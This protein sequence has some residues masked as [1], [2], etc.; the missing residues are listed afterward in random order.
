MLYCDVV[1]Y[2]SGIYKKYLNHEVGLVFVRC[3]ILA[4]L[5]RLYNLTGKIVSKVGTI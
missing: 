5:L 4:K 3:N 2:N 1:S